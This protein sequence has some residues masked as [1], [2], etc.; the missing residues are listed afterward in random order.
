MLS[1]DG[2]D[3]HERPVRGSPA[4]GASHATGW[5]ADRILAAVELTRTTDAVPLDSAR[6]AAVVELLRG[7]DIAVLSGA[8]IS[9]ENPVSF[10]DY[11]SGL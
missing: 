8:G 1:L 2:D 9:T 5:G 4:A 6:L 7:G 10:P 3:S 11:G